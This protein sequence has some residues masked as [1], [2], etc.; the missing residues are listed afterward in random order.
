MSV[1]GYI[2]G[3]FNFESAFCR[4]RKFALRCRV[5][6][7]LIN[8]DFH[9]IV[10]PYFNRQL[11]VIKMSVLCEQFFSGK[12]RAKFRELLLHKVQQ[13]QITRISTE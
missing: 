8:D 7:Y 2:G 4:P 3:T 11:N 1:C 6:V 10:P 13:L 9:A 5:A 12:H